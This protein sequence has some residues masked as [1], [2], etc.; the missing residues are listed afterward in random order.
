M[1]AA[2][3]VD[4][5]QQPRAIA[6]Q[7]ARTA[8]LY[9]VLAG[10][11]I[12]ASSVI[13]GLAV[14]HRLEAE[15]FVEIG[16]GLGFVAAT[17]GL[18]YLLLER[19]Q[20]RLQ[21]AQVSLDESR[22][23]TEAQRRRIERIARIGHWVWHADPNANDWEGGR[24]AYSES[25]A[26][27][28]G[29]SPSELAISNREYIDRF[30][31]PDDRL[32][33][34]RHFSNPHQGEPGTTLAEYR[35][36]R[37]DGEVR[38]I[39]E[40]TEVVTSPSGE[41]TFWQGTV[42][43]VT[44][45]RKIEADLVES[46]ARF[47]DFAEV[48]SQFQWEIDE[49]FKIVN[50]SGQ[51]PE[52]MADNSREVIGK[53]FREVAGLESGLTD[54]HWVA[55]ER[56]LLLHEP[57]HDFPYTIL[58]GPGQ[59]RHR[60]AS[61]RP[62]FDSTGRFRGYRGVTGDETKEAEARQRAQ[63]A[64]DLLARAVESI[65]DGFAIY[66]SADRLVMMNS[67][68][69]EGFPPNQSGD[70]A[71]KTF[72]ALV[73]ADVARGY[74][75]DAVGREEAFI[76]Q[77]MAAHRK[78]GNVHIFKNDKGRWTQARDQRLPD[79]SIVAIRT[80]VTELV[81]RGEAL[82]RSQ[83][84]LTAAQ[85]IARM[86][87]WEFDIENVEEMDRN[88]L[89]WSDETFRIFG[90]EPGQIEVSNESFFHVVLPEDRAMIR[91]AV[92]RA[93]HEG[94][95][96]NVEHRV[97]RPDGSEI[98]VRDV[99][100]VIRDPVTSRPLKLV[101]TIQD[102]TEVKRT[103]DALRQAQKME[104]IGQL[105]GGIAHDFNNLL[106]VVGGNLELLLEGLEANQQRLRRFAGIAHDAVLR[107]GDLTQRLLAF[108]RRQSLKPDVIDANRLIGNLVPLLHRTLGEQIAV[109]TALTPD[110]WPTLCDGGQIENALLNLAVNAR[111]AMPNGG[112]LVIRTENLHL[113]QEWAAETR[114]LQP[115]DYVM[116]AVSDTGQGMPPQVRDRAFEPFF[117]TKETGRGTGLGLSM[118]Y[119]FVKQSGG[120]VSIYSEV[121]Q[122][123][124]VK[125]FLPRTGEDAGAQG[126]GKSE[127]VLP[128]GDE[129]I[130]LVEDEDMVRSTVASMLHDLGYRVSEASDGNEAL[131]LIAS[132]PPF[133]LILSDVVMPGGLSGWELAQ[134]AWLKQPRLKFLFSTGY[135]DNPILQQAHLDTR[136]HVLPKPYSKRALAVMLRSVIDRPEP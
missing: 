24:S 41:R 131:S 98:I 27:I 119:G 18:L 39:Y 117:T 52:L 66:D 12:A 19:V 62:I 89:R 73:R 47:R 118:V 108:A 100:E 30:V 115:G 75:P 53:T 121:G 95:P 21:A 2:N 60:R 34:A 110:V 105:T 46:E 101:G 68:Y 113:D 133:D 14:E 5:R 129:R 99:A 106:M 49:N 69:R 22:Q 103:E 96:Y 127:A 81:E 40:V 70:P 123:T 112:K 87:S 104:A 45:I 80:D 77:R 9:A 59:I 42:Q 124:T 26:A 28:F 86:G 56:L 51:R 111:D 23:T 65:S 36:V 32:R 11:W 13:S 91:R 4:H 1:E 48:A 82:C 125:L 31:H 109:E 114:D 85:R 136:I 8:I 92:E 25:A 44:E 132:H 88:P 17:G 61:G 83:A 7:P 120:H 93:I 67:K 64:E 57:F 43:D 72:E 116:L 128:R 35:I 29:V 55:F 134:A 15:V 122:G 74:Y 79:G 126:Q 102:I 37:P 135:T 84:N 90:F 20:R 58:V 10:I 38:T 107:G 54:E 33:V 63:A 6:L 78:S 130:L 71:G 50:Y 16:K 94:V 3:N 76:A 97:I